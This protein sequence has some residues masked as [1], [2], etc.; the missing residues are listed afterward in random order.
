MPAVSEKQR[1][2]FGAVMGAKK[3]KPGSSGEA[4]EV[5]K[6]MPESKI[7]DFLHKE[8]SD[9]RDVY[10]QGF[11]DKCASIGVNPDEL[12]KQAGILG[13]AG[14]ALG[15][16]A[17]KAKPMVGAAVDAGKGM[18]N[19]AGELLSGSGVRDREAQLAMNNGFGA[20][21]LP[22]QELAG[23]KF[24]SLMS[25]LGLGTTL[26]GGVGGAGYE[27]EKKRQQAQHPIMARLHALLG[28]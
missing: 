22:G 1:R 12:L 25:Q 8:S 15:G 14:E 27:I 7:K 26:A 19:R 13:A 24:K 28:R 4:K 3:G 2:F 23:E 16:L 9:P 17:A 11:C 10:A 5:A 20:N 6:E 21:G 18:F